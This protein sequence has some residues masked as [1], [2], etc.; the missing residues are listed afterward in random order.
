MNEADVTEYT[1]HH[2]APHNVYLVPLLGE[3]SQIW[4]LS[5]VV[6]LLLLPSPMVFP[7]L[8]VVF[9][10]KTFWGKNA[11]FGDGA[12]SAIPLAR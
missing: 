1:V 11:V 2:F 10:K 4:L 8:L 12:L 3:G 5:T 6:I 7:I 9:F